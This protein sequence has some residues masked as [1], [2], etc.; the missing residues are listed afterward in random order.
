MYLATLTL[1]PPRTALGEKAQKLSIIGSGK[2]PPLSTGLSRE[3]SPKYS[4]TRI[5][6][7]TTR[8]NYVRYN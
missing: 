8:R 2:C 6:A 1:N 3:D 4:V 5:T 7:T